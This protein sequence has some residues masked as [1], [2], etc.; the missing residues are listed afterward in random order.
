M[1]QAVRNVMK[2]TGIDFQQALRTATMNPARAAG[3][4]GQRG[5]LEAGAAADLVVFN[6]RQEV[7]RTIVAGRGI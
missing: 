3:L 1:D 5:R 7:V 4:P 2:F 6:R